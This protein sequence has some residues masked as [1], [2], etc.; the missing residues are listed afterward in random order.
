LHEYHHSKSFSRSS[1]WETPAI[2]EWEAG[3]PKSLQPHL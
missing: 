1:F 2:A 3:A